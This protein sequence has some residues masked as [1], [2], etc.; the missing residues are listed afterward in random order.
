MRNS[1]FGSIGVALGLALLI[2]SL[3]AGGSSRHGSGAYAAGEPA[4]PSPRDLARD[5]SS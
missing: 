3:L 1:I 5:P 2:G 4:V